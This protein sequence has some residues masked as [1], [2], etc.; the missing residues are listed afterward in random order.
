MPK[1]NRFLDWVLGRRGYWTSEDP[2][3]STE[4]RERKHEPELDDDDDDYIDIGDVN[5]ICLAC[6]TSYHQAI[7]SAPFKGSLKL[8]YNDP[9]SQKWL[10]GNKYI[11]HEATDTHP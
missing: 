9:E 7:D 3:R 11:L 1:A 6:G 2:T 5:D 8:M 4:T 10:I